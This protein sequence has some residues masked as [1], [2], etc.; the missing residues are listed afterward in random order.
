[1][2]G[3]G[4][5]HQRTSQGKGAF[6]G[7]FGREDLRFASDHLQLGNRSYLSRRPEPAAS[8]QRVR[9]D[10]WILSPKETWKPWLKGVVQA[11][12]FWLALRLALAS[13]CSRKRSPRVRLRHRTLC[14]SCTTR[15]AAQDIPVAAGVLR[16][17]NRSEPFTE[18][19]SFREC[20]LRA[21]PLRFRD[22]SRSCGWEVLCRCRREP[23]WLPGSPTAR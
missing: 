20:A 22:P 2:H 6:P 1:M 11:S 12:R 9:G 17:T 13:E 19:D 3:V 8:F 16:L 7:R 5:S 4:R 14:R 23:A 15:G 21:F 18:A 10:S